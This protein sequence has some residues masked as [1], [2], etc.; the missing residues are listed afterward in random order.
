MPA[1]CLTVSV[2]VT[3][4]GGFLSHGFT[5][6]G[7]SPVGRAVESGHADGPMSGM[8]PKRPICQQV[9]R[10]TW[11]GSRRCGTHRSRCNRSQTVPAERSRQSAALVFVSI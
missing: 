8:M 7:Y 10:F 11:F 5:P 6:E 1:I 2:Q 9:F 4:M 3:L